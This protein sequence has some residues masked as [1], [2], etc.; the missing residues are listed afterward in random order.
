MSHTISLDIGGTFSD[1]FVQMDDGRMFIGKHSTTPAHVDTCFM[2]AIEAAREKIGISMEELISNTSIISYST[3]MPVNSLIQRAGPKLGMITTA[4]FEDFN[5]IARGRGYGDGLPL[6]EIRLFTKCHKPVPLIERRLTV[7]IDERIDWN[8]NVVIPLKREK[9]EEKLAYLVDEGVRGI[10]VS[11]L[12]SYVNPANERAVKEIF[13]EMYPDKFMGSMPILLG[14]DIFPVYEEYLRTN[15]AI[16]NAYMHV[17]LADALH[18]V[19]EKLRYYGY[20]KPLLIIKNIG[21]MGAITR[22]S[23]IEVYNSGPVSGLYGSCSVGKNLY[24]QEKIIMGDMGGTSYDIGVVADGDVKFYSAFPTI[25]R[26]RVGMPIIEVRSIGAGGGS[27]AWINKMGRLEVGPKSAGSTPGPVCYNQGGKEPTVTDADVVLGYINPDKFAYGKMK[28]DVRKAT[29]VIKAKIADPLGMNVPEAAL[30]IKRV[31]D[32]FMGTEMYADLTLKGHD[33]REFDFYAFGGAG[34]GHC[35][36]LAD[37]LGCK[38]ILTF[39]FGPA[40]C[41]FGACDMD[42]V[43]KY[44]L[45][46]S[47]HPLKPHTQELNN[48]YETFNQIVQGLKD[49]AIIDMAWEGLDVKEIEFKLELEMRYGIQ[50]SSTRVE[51]PII[52]LNSEG[53]VKTVIKTF[54]KMYTEMYG[55]DAASPIGGVEVVRFRLITSKSQ[56]KAEFKKFPLQHED[57]GA[58]KI[59]TRDAYWGHGYVPT[60]VYDL[61]KLQCGNVVKGPAIIEHDVT[62]YVI[63]PTWQYYKDEYMNGQITKKA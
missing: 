59:G 7:G 38:R 54:E 43:H 34:A 3:T 55:E 57:P 19:G 25:E 2:G 31:I 8:G 30:G 17:E 51:S 32:S 45:T 63:P 22:S 23:A 4:G 9:V 41:A 50:Y 16:L 11:L 27:I 48:D 49:Q 40:F 15:A 14:S 58:A 60:N 13:L 35:C 24:N 20:N 62:T 26:F 12:N 6:S 52:F 21:G 44:E 33:P 47:Y 1:C 39:P 53:D 36:G 5:D 56:R 29:D 46:A 37:N 28:L 42:I 10:V 61:D 18:T